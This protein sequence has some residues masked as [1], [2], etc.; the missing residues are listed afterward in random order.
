[1]IYS[2]SS[3]NVLLSIIF[4]KGNGEGK[5]DTLLNYAP[6]HEGM[7]WSRGTAPLVFNLSTR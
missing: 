7:W 1:L 3:Q 6:W 2:V 5:S 4:L